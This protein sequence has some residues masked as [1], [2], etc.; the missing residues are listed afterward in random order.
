MDATENGTTF[1]EGLVR[2]LEALEHENAELRGKVAAM[3]G[4]AATA[5]RR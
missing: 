1:L 5:T 3:E 4:Q 2:R